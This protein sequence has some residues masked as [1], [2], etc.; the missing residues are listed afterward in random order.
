[1]KILSIDAWRN[2]EG[3]NWNQWWNAGEIAKE[4][5]ESCKTDRDFLKLMKKEG[6]ITTIDKKRV[7]VEDDQHNICIT[8]KDGQ[9]IF[10][11]CYG[12]EY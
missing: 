5:F 8:G 4:Q 9:P 10:A 3:W 1:M 6:Y 2:D 12:E 11:I 7:G